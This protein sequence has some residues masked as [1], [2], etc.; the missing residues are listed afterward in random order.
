MPFSRNGR[1]QGSRGSTMPSRPPRL[2]LVA[3]LVLGLAPLVQAGAAAGRDGAPPPAS[4]AAL[5]S[6]DD[7]FSRAASLAGWDVMQ[8]EVRKGG[9]ARYDAGRTTP[10][11]LTI[12]SSTSWWVHDMH[13]FYL[14]RQASGDFKVTIRIRASGRRSA[15]PRANWSLSGLLVRAPTEDP[16]AESWIGWTVGAVSGTPV[17]ERKTT[18]HSFSELRL[19][20][21]RPGWVE[22]RVVRVGS[23]F[24]LLRRYPGKPWVLQHAYLRP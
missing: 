4:G 23:T 3:A 1:Y 2:L 7:E 22:L 12:F 15:L 11:A 9:P 14:S 13:A 21:A 17:F 24:A 10:G 5:P 16:E 20:P 6:L 19:V 8:G 18:A